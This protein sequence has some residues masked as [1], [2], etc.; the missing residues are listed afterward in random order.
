MIQSAWKK[1]S[2]APFEFGFLDA[3][4]ELLYQNEQKLGTIGLVFSGLGIMIATL[5]LLGLVTYMASQRTKEIGIRKVMGA[6]VQQVVVLL[7][8]DFIKTILLA[9]IITLLASFFFINK[10]L[11]TFPYKVKFDFIIATAAGV[12]VLPFAWLVV[13]DQRLRAAKCKSYR[14]FE[15]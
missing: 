13:I 2:G 8:K 14:K 6:T 15:K 10:W 4:Y 9:L 5:G 11:E 12:M 1:Y 3:K 7:S